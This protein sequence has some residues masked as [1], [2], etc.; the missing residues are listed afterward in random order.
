MMRKPPQRDEQIRVLHVDDDPSILDLTQTFLE[1][2]NDRFSIKIATSPEEGLEVL[3]D[4]PPDCIISDY[5]MPR[6]DGIDFLEKVREDHP[7]LPF[8]LYTGKGSEEVASEAISAGVTDYLQKESGTDQ[9]RILA[10][11]ITNIIAQTRAEQKVEETQKYYGQILEHA[12]D[13]VMIVDEHGRVDYVSPAVER[14]MGY[15]PDELENFDAFK[16]IHP[17]DLSVA[18]ETFTNV[19][20]HPEKEHVVEYRARHSDGSWRWLEVRGRNLLDNPVIE[21]I[22]VSVR[23]ITERIEYQ[24]ELERQ[25]DLF[26]KAQA[27]ADVGGWEYDLEADELTW[28]EQVYQIFGLSTDYNPT[29]QNTIEFYHPD[30]RETI[31]E[32]FARAVEEGD[33]YD[34]KL[35]LITP[36]GNTRWVRIQGVPQTKDDEIT[37]IR[38][39]IQDI[40]EQKE[41]EQELESERRFIQQAIDSLNDL[42]YVLD[43]DG[44]I[45]QWNDSVSE[46]TGYKESEIESMRAVEFFPT[47][48]REPIAKA[49]ERTLKEGKATM[50]ADVLTAD[51][52]RIPHE[53]T[54]ARLTDEDG[55]TTGMVG[56]GR[57]ITERKE[58]EQRLRHERERYSTL[59]ET[60]P[61]PV[62]HG[63]AEDDKPVVQMVNSAFEETFG[64]DA[65]VITGERLH[66]YILPDDS[67]GN[68]EGLNQRI[69][70]KGDISTEVQRETIDG[71]R[72]FQLDVNTRSTESGDIHGYAV[73]TD[74]TERKEYEQELVAQKEQLEELADVIGHDLREPL[75]V[76]EGSLELVQKTGDSD[77]LDRVADAIDRAQTLLEDL[78][79]LARAGSQVGEIESVTLADVAEQSW[80]TVETKS[81][82]L[83]IHTEL[84]ICADRSRLQQLFENLYRN[85]VEHG[86]RGVTIS[87]GTMDGGFYVADTG[88]GIPEVESEQIFETGFSTSADGTGFGLRI[89]EKIAEAHGW[90]ITVIDSERDG[91]RF[92]F[93]D[94]ELT[95]VQKD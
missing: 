84:L 44:S 23:D 91:V 62:L 53:L 78:L 43:K 42:F 73:Y 12:S 11:R 45:R 8:I 92:E 54:G 30:A 1:R 4:T 21:G 83:E 75:S 70:D 64:Y 88:C 81:A 77:H 60:L 94:V 24:Q 20:E 46:V 48:D 2:E 55:N 28:T 32:A 9:Y 79:T 14:V 40:T 7:D 61:T 16:S 51:G 29:N 25:N 66:E 90:E 58:R 95:G 49:I 27:M 33:P 26:T 57:D 80:Q 72:T 10:N 34:I 67:T 89:V 87:V 39:T 37:R 82:T 56:L 13:Y 19:L 69:I 18:S 41:R 93:T 59:F 74:I 86:G 52:K 71:T 35:R 85:A 63:K 15:T 17:E 3:R 38:G 47:E 36:E 68:A 22:I 31:R 6:L 76:A 50:E 65:E 5:E